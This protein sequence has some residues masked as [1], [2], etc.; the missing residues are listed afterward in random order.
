[1][2]LYSMHRDASHWQR[3]DEFD[4]ERFIQM[5]DGEPTLV[6]DEWLQ[7]FGY[8]KKAFNIIIKISFAPL[9]DTTI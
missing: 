1:M 6:Q 4:P 7:P 9:A 5:L 3:P 8:G 2:N